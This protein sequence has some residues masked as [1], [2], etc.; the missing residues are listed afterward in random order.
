MN[1][2]ETLSL[3]VDDDDPCKSPSFSCRLVTSQFFSLLPFNLRIAACVTCGFRA[4]IGSAGNVSKNGHEVEHW[5]DG[6]SETVGT[7]MDW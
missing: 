2:E 5:I 4:S 6:L 7:G 3:Y 1:V